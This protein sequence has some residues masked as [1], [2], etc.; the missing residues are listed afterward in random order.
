M[1][2]NV[3]IVEVHWARWHGGRRQLGGYRPCNHFQRSGMLIL[4]CY[5]VKF[6]ALIFWSGYLQ[7]RKIVEKLRL[8]RQ[9]LGAA[10]GY[11]GSGG[12]GESGGGGGGESGGGVSQ[13][14]ENSGVRYYYN[15]LTSRPYDSL[16]REA[17]LM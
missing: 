8:G 15:L 5:W 6:R 12:G 1:R 7:Y 14:H 17:Y 13:A 16:Q 4:M 3:D 9:K 2:K 11:Q 10:L